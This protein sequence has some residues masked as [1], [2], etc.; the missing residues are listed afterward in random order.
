MRRAQRSASNR[1]TELHFTADDGR[2][3]PSLCLNPPLAPEGEPVV[4]AG[5][6]P[7]MGGGGEPDVLAPIAAGSDCG[8][9]QGMPRSTP[10]R[11]TRAGHLHLAGSRPPLPI[12]PVFDT[13]PDSPSALA[14]PLVGL[15]PPPLTRTV[16]TAPCVMRR[17]DAGR[18]SAPKLLSAAQWPSRAFLTADVSVPRVVRLRLSDARTARLVG[19]SV[20]H[21]D[22]GGRIV[23]TEGIRMHL[24]VD[25]NADVFA[26]FVDGDVI[27][28][29]SVAAVNAVLDTPGTVH[30]V[31]TTTDQTERAAMRGQSA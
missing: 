20:V 10:P 11:T 19:S 8:T 27:E 22:T 6:E 12:R 17:L 18:L 29:R 25:P 2:F 26:R 5:A 16:Q 1:E 15:Q 23:L 9:G 7:Q 14:G 30:S 28:V 31:T 3:D 24:A 21:T 4:R 13:T